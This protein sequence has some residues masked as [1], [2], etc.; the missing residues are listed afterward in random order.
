MILLKM[1]AIVITLVM[2]MVLEMM[3]TIIILKFIIVVMKPHDPL[4]GHRR[5]PGYNSTEYQTKR[6]TE[7]HNGANKNNA[8]IKQVVCRT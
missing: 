2:P 6:G 3:M 1:I 5:H 4:G 8:K 7:I